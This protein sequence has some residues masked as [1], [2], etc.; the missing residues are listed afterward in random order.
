MNPSSLFEMKHSIVK[1]VS[2]YVDVEAE[3]L[4]EVRSPSTQ[5]LETRSVLDS[6]TAGTQPSVSS[7][8][9]GVDSLLVEG[10]HLTHAASHA[11]WPHSQRHAQR[12]MHVRQD[13]RW[14]TSPTKAV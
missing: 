13:L 3:E 12:D 11:W 1:A 6:C 7:G 8:I 5:S 10:D 14:A 2:E 4:V 9:E